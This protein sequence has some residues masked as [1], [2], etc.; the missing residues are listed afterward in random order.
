[1]A[2]VRSKKKEKV[3]NSQND[4]IIFEI[5]ETIILIKV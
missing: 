5:A 1:M 4:N 2:E 3:L